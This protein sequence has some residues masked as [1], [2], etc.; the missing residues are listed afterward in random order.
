METS[1][2]RKAQNE[3]EIRK[4]LLCMKAHSVSVPARLGLKFA[5]QGQLA[6]FFDKQ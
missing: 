2:Y 5:Y 1:E 4:G 6:W 3:Q